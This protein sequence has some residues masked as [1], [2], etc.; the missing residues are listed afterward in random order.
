MRR[1]WRRFEVGKTQISDNTMAQWQPRLSPRTTVYR[2]EPLWNS[3]KFDLS[4]SSAIDGL[5][6]MCPL[7]TYEF[8]PWSSGEN[9]ILRIVRMDLTTSNTKIVT[10]PDY[11]R[12]TVYIDRRQDRITIEHTNDLPK[13][14]CEYPDQA[15]R[16]AHYFDKPDFDCYNSVYSCWYE[17]DL[18]LGRSWRPSGLSYVLGSGWGLEDLCLDGCSVFGGCFLEVLLRCERPPFASQSVR[19][20]LVRHGRRHESNLV[21]LTLLRFESLVH[22]RHLSTFVLHCNEVFLLFLSNAIESSHF[23]LFVN[24]NQASRLELCLLAAKKKL[25]KL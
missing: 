15:K 20:G 25:N 6:C 2:D 22:P 4:P 3:F 17:A 8:Y 23:V 19:L 11:D 18:D 10:Q 14:R 12:S 13:Y 24:W 1:I 9:S 5:P 7:W 16:V 21:W